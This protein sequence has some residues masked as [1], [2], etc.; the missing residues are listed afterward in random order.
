MIENQW[1]EISIPHLPR[2]ASGKLPK[3][4][5]SFFIFYAFTFHY[6]IHLLQLRAYN[7]IDI[8]FQFKTSEVSTL[9]DYDWYQL[10][11][12]WLEADDEN[13]VNWGVLLSNTF[14]KEVQAT[15]ILSWMGKDNDD[16]DDDDKNDHHDEVDFV[17]SRMVWSY[18]TG[19]S[20]TMMI[21]AMI[22][23]IIIIL[24]S[25][26]WSDIVQRGEGQRFHRNRTHPGSPPLHIQYGVIFMM[27]MMVMMVWNL[28][29]R[30][31]IIIVIFLFELSETLNS[32]LLTIQQPS[33]LAHHDLSLI[34]V[35]VMIITTF[36]IVDSHNEYHHQVW[37]SDPK[38]Q[39]SHVARG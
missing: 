25:A 15:I 2:H 33:V 28:D 10:R 24:F 32:K 36:I 19:E 7:L 9:Y 12:W 1:K 23:K 39:L 13:S 4:W 31:S 22:M 38:R 20:K 35:L 17:P 11:L 16:D 3:Y 8:Y 21:M 34:T 29:R 26:G 27:M 18:A 14:D 37:T 30:R 6:C 5:K